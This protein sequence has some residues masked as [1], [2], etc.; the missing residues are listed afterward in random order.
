[1][2]INTRKPAAVRLDCRKLGRG[3]V[4]GREAQHPTLTHPNMTTNT[5]SMVGMNDVHCYGERRATEADIFVKPSFL[6]MKL[7]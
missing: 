7:T 3:S 2:S 1:M 4:W 5:I 6:G